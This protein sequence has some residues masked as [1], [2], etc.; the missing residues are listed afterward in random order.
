M[1]LEHLG[2]AEAGAAVL[3]A[4]EQVL[5]A[6]PGHAP[7]TRDIGG[8]ASTSDLGQAIAEAL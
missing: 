5:A 2:H 6:G 4:I 3:A 1:M 7:L 8:T